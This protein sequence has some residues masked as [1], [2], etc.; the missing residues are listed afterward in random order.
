M[1]FQ[2]PAIAVR[3]LLDEKGRG[4]LETAIG[5]GGIAPHH[6]LQREIA[7][8]Q[9][10]AGIGRDVARDAALVGEVDD[11]HDAGFLERAHSRNVARVPQGLP[12]GDGAPE[13]PLVVLGFV[14]LHI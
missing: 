8:T 5:D 11:V 14:G 10:H 2:H 1:G 9:R 3:H 12:D 13:I 7:G 6:L 4:C